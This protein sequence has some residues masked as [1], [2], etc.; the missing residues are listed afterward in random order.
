MNILI[1]GLGLIGKERL[2]GLKNLDSKNEFNISIIDPNGGKNVDSTPNFGNSISL[3]TLKKLNFIC[4][5]NL[6]NSYDLMIIS[7]PHLESINFLKE[8]HYL[9]KKI[10]IE[11]AFGLNLKDSLEIN[12]ITQNKKI[13][14]GLNYRFFDGV[15]ALKKDLDNKTFGE[16]ININLELGLG[17][18][19]GAENTWR[20]Q[21]NQIPKGALF[22]PGIHLIDLINFLFEGINLNSAVSWNGFWNKNYPEDIIFNGTSKVGGNIS[23]HISNVHWKSTF[24]IKVVGSEGYGYING[25]GRSYGQQ[26][27]LRG[28]KWG[29]ENN[30]SQ[31]DSEELVTVSDCENSFTKELE[32]II[33][34]DGLCSADSDDVISAFKIIEKIENLF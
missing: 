27:Y 9:S 32:D 23:C 5:K 13:F 21:Y 3:D 31:S 1:V 16:L 17:H 4:E 7:A 14:T 15:Q 8:Y 25:R 34:D 29:W 2:N 18:Q 28:K 33:F 6:D 20:L 19:R 12:S 30:I 11:K 22:D 26:K 24:T 10:L